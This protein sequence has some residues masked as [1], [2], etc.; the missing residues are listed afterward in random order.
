MWG[1]GNKSKSARIDSLLGRE[2]QVNGDIRFVGGLHLDGRVTGKVSSEGDPSA[3]LQVSPQGIVEGNIDV[4]NIVIGGTVKGEIRAIGKV[5]LS[6]TARV[7]GDVYY[8]RIQMAAGAEINGQLVYC[9]SPSGE[10]LKL[11][12]QPRPEPPGEPLEEPSA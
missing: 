12:H 8:N 6:S 3:Y 1:S 9:R 5:E 11:K 2:T 10:P 4:P 7:D